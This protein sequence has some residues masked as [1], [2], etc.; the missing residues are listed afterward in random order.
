MR[1]YCTAFKQSFVFLSKTDP[2]HYYFVFQGGNLKSPHI[3]NQT[4]LENSIASDSLW[5]ESLTNL[6]WHGVYLRSLSFP[7]FRHPYENRA[8][9][10]RI[11]SSCQ[12]GST[13]A[14]SST[15]IRSCRIWR[16]CLA[17]TRRL[18]QK[19]TMSMMLVLRYEYDV[20]QYALDNRHSNILCN[21][22]W[23]LM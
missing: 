12:L 1:Q 18:D 7:K 20:L 23:Y 16:L 22:W 9:K 19:N 2:S 11:G 5:T 8:D 4:N 10:Q 3:T 6:P 15:L 14:K 13:T 17:G 21:R